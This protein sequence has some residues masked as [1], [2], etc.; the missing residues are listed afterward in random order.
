VE[1]DAWSKLIGKS[2]V[3]I[4]QEMFDQYIAGDRVVLAAGGLAADIFADNLTYRM[5]PFWAEHWS[6]AV[7]RVDA[8]AQ[9]WAAYQA[10]HGGRLLYI[11]PPWNQLGRV[12]QRLITQQ[13]NAVVVY[14]AWNRPWQ[15]LWS[16]VKPVHVITLPAKRDLLM[17]GPRSGQAG[18]V[19]AHYRVHA[20][21]IQWSA[22]HT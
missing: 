20:A 21:V 5:K 18:I 10:A 6:P 7:D 15:A 8:W 16:A 11:N 4:K 2:Q 14:P 19:E 12:L 22:S 1:A 3:M 17:A 13:V 9:D